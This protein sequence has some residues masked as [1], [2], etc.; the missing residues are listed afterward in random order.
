MGVGH[1]LATSVTLLTTCRFHLGRGREVNSQPLFH[2]SVRTRMDK[3]VLKYSPKAQY[4][5]GTE[6][7]VT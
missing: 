6:Q 4:E 1:R 2:E 7:Y 3:P 5:K